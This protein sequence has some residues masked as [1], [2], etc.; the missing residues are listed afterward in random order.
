MNNKALNAFKAYFNGIGQ[1]MFQ[2]SP[3]TGILFLAGIFWGAYAAHMPAVAWGAVVGTA[4]ST[5]AGY[6]TTPRSTDGVQGLY[7]FNGVLVG[8]ALP[9]FLAPTPLMWATI[10]FI[11][12]ASTWVRNALNNVMGPWKVTS[13]TF[14]FVLLTWMVLLASG[15]LTG[16]KG[17]ELSTA[18][19]PVHVESTV[20]PSMDFVS[21]LEYWLKGVAQVFLINNWITGIIFLVALAVCSR[22]AAFWAAVASAI[23]LAMV[24][25][26]KGSGADISAG[27]FGFSPVLT[28]IAVG[29]T[30]YKPSW[31]SALWAIAAIIATVFIQAG[32]DALV[33]PLGIPTLTGPFCVA[34]WL[35]MLPQFNFDNK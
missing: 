33:S 13:Y 32:M 29:C 19:L 8:C 11:S 22:W 10:V 21:L 25:L 35:F 6:L 26:F 9:T 20:M 12:M 28:G 24:I 3:W 2:E 7:G 14:P 30:F 5:I 31:R 18:A 4:A 23:A 17:V 16:L 34:T 27:L 15:V 1:V